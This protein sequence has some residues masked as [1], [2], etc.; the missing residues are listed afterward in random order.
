MKEPQTVKAHKS[1]G[2]TPS[3][4]SG[5]ATYKLKMPYWAYT[6]RKFLDG[7]LLLFCNQALCFY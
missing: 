6:W 1:C 4:D 5:T 3:K 7:V 2:D